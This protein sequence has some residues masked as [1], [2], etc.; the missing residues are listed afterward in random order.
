MRK[1]KNIMR[2]KAGK[3]DEEEDEDVMLLFPYTRFTTVLHG[4]FRVDSKLYTGTLEILNTSIPTHQLLAN[5]FTALTCPTNGSSISASVGTALGFSISSVENKL[6]TIG[7]DSYGYIQSGYNGETY[8]T[9]CLTRCNGHTRKITDGTCSGIGCCQVDVPRA[10]KN[11][12]IHADYF[13]NSTTDWGNCTA[14]FV[15]KDGSYNFSTKDLSNFEY[16]K[17]PLVLDWTV[18]ENNSRRIAIATN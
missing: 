3:E 4:R 16:E 8:T 12:S 15:V 7:C 9:G 10:M 1:S 13:R 17:L 18:G 11:V 5:S 6:V 2:Y 14:S